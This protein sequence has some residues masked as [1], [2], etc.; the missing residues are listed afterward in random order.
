[1]KIADVGVARHENEITGTV[2]TTSIYLA[3]EVFEKRICNSKSDMYSFGYVLWELWYGETAFAAA[4]E[5]TNTCM[6]LEDV[7]KQDLRPTHI[8]GTQHPWGSWQLVME[9]CWNKDP[10]VRLTAQKGW[11]KL[12]QREDFQQKV[13]PLQP[14]PA[15][16]SP[17]RLVPP[18]LRQQ[19]KREDFQQNESPPPLPARSSSR[20]LAPPT[21]PK[22]AT[23]PK[24]REGKAVSYHRETEEGMVDFE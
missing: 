6:V 4:I 9:S 7:V 2:C 11:E 3:P 8:E 21:K 20:R 1:M 17:P 5:S 18:S 15:K 22:P 16:S 14:Q 10:E 24:S 12:Q 19:Q 13:S 23:R